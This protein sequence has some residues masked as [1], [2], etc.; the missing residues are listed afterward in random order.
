MPGR[1][2]LRMFASASVATYV[3]PGIHDMIVVEPPPAVQAMPVQS[4]VLFRRTTDPTNY[5]EAI[6]RS[7]ADR[8]Q[9]AMHAEL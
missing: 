2:N 5:Q 6:E 9:N 1:I 8:W 3:Q 4:R 7:D